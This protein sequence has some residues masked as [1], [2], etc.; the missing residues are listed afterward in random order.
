MDFKVQ[1]I[2]ITDELFPATLRKIKKPPQ[3]LYYCGRFLVQENCLAI[4]GAR[5]CSKYGQEC[6]LEI[7]ADLANSNI[8]LVSG[9]ARGIDSFAHFAAVKNKKRTIAVLGT[10]LTKESFYPKE[11]LNLAQQILENDGLI[12][13]E[14]AADEKTGPYS[15]IE[16]NRLIAGL[17]LGTLVIEAKE[18]S[19]SLITAENTLAQG[20]HLFALPGNIHSPLSKGCHALIKAGAKLVENSEDILKELKIARLPNI[21]KNDKPTLEY[22]LDEIK[23][24]NALETDALDIESLIKNTSLPVNKI[25]SLLAS[26]EIKNKITNLGDNTFCLNRH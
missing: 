17:A 14:Y 8:T 21:I 10:A 15:F 26:L 24:I 19:G 25:I 7:G 18:K 16:R 9:L 23:I 2:S 3:T 12:L 5:N 20:K 13:S 11:N 6:C 22:S 1:K 4:V